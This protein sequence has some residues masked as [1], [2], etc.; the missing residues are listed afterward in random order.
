MY[1]FLGYTWHR[2]YEEPILC[3]DETRVEA[4]SLRI[5]AFKLIRQADNASYSARFSVVRPH[6]PVA[7]T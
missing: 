5:F 4:T 6:W 2:P 1:A 3:T 7:N